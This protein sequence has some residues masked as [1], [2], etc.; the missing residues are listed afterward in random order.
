MLDVLFIERMRLTKQC[1]VAGSKFGSQL[2][3]SRPGYR[4]EFG[5]PIDREVG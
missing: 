1:L 3:S 4:R 5:D 2:D